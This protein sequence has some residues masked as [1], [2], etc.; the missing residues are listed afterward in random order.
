MR[1]I[2]LLLTSVMMVLGMA[3]C[4]GGG[5]GEEQSTNTPEAAVAGYL[6][7]FKAVD[8]AK[9]NEYVTEDDMMYSE[10]TTQDNTEEKIIFE[11]ITYKI[12]SLVSLDTSEE[13]N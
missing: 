4:G 11:N 1:K 9:L 8:Q 2:L 10:D 5:G 12:K 6:D 7:A 13:G 3:A